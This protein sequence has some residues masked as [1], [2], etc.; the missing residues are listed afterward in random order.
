M[1]ISSKDAIQIIAEVTGIKGSRQTLKTW[2]DQGR[3]QRTP[4]HTKCAMYDDV[5]V[6]QA[7]IN[8]RNQRNAGKQQSTLICAGLEV[9]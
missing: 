7:A 9:R 2:A 6:R 1:L 5:E 3:I 4:I 8:T